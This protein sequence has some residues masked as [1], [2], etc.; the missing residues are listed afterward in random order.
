MVP[1]ERLGGVSYSP[2]IVTMALSCISSEMKRDIGRKSRVFHTAPAFDAPVQGVPVKI[3]PSRLVWKTIM[4]GLSEGEKNF[5]DMCNRL[6]TISA[7]GGQTDR[8]LATT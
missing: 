2:S 4:V 6:N 3:L 1:F 7:C 8:Q 5:E